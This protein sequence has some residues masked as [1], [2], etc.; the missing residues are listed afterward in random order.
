MALIGGGGAGN[1]GGGNPSGIGSSLNYIG[2][3]AYANSGAIQTE[4]SA[5]PHLNFTTGNEYIIG[6]FE[7]QGACNLSDVSDGEVSAFIIKINSEIVAQPK[8]GTAAEAMPTVEHYK[9]LIT[10]QSKIEVEVISAASNTGWKTSASF[11]GR[12]YA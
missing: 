10:P 8:V 11:V 4:T 9:I 3:H 6:V 12:V 2:N 7:L 1:V 5:A